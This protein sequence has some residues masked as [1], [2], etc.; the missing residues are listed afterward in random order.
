MSSLFHSFLPV[1]LAVLFPVVEPNKS[2]HYIAMSS[3]DETQH[4]GSTMTYSTNNFE[5]PLNLQPM[6]FSSQSEI[7]VDILVDPTDVSLPKSLSEHVR[8]YFDENDSGCF[9]CLHCPFTTTDKASMAN[10]HAPCHVQKARHKCPSCSF[11]SDWADIVLAHLNSTHA[12]GVKA[13]GGRA[14][15][16]CPFRTRFP[17]QFSEHMLMHVSGAC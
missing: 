1:I 3:Q 5:P 9:V 15:H 8:Y 2:L 14:C 6:D 7:T 16:H 12:T 11:S 13:V 17:M 4:N 10:E